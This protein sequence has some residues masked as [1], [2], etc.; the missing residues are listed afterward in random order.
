MR[1]DTIDDIMR[2]LHTL[3]PQRIA[4]VENFVDFLMQR[5]QPARTDQRPPLNFPVI[6]VRQWPDDLSIRREDLYNDDVL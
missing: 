4:E 5:S 1:P 6:N 2:K 3:S